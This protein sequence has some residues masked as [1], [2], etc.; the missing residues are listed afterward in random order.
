MK[1]MVAATSGLLLIAAAAVNAADSGSRTYADPSC[2]DRNANPENCV[3]QDGGSRRGSSVA[4]V[5][6]TEFKP[7]PTSATPSASAGAGVPAPTGSG[8]GGNA[9]STPAAGS[10]QA[11]G[12]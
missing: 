3:V 5:P 9:G 7:P 4:P 12:K 1:K 11:G 2:S 8:S 6:G 10:A